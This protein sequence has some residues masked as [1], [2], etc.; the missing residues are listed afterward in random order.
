[1]KMLKELRAALQATTQKMQAIID[2]SAGGFSAEDRAEFDNLTALSRTQKED[3]ARVEGAESLNAELGASAGRRTE[4]TGGVDRATLDK[5]AGF[6]G[7]EEFYRTIRGASF[8][9][10]DQR[11]EALKAAAGP[12]Q[13]GENSQYG[14][15][16]PPQLSSDLLAAIDELDEFENLASLCNVEPTNAAMVKFDRDEYLP[17]SAGGIT[18]RCRDEL[19]AMTAQKTI[20]PK[21]SQ[22][23]PEGLYVYIEAGDELLSDAPR[24]LNRLTVQAANA[25]VHKQNTEILEGTGAGQMLGILNASN[26]A[27]IS[28]AKK[29][30]Q[31]ADT[32]VKENIDGI[33]N[34]VTPRA[35]RRGFWM[36]GAGV[37]SAIE[38]ISQGNNNLFMPAGG[39][40][41]LSLA[42]LRGRPVV[43]TEY[44]PELGSQND[45]IFVD[46]QAYKI[47]ERQS[48]EYA[49]SMHILFDQAAQAFRWTKRINGMPRIATP[50]SRNKAGSDY[51]M[52]PFVRL[53]ARG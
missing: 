30:S 10:T 50:I 15:L 29:V 27:L 18:A 12:N 41:E 44:L 22:L 26:S 53:E 35:K 21:Q 25:L 34:R 9:Q 51:T 19:A 5:W 17:W 45:L 4:I 28:V 33:W 7:A 13:H 8:G 49:T 48:V 3:L 14:Y 20:P 16:A 39:L 1:M 38:G 52:S 47:I 11:L 40:T 24:M 42:R 31:A 6:K 23:E 2:R 37:L 36:C 43:E 32:V 46:F